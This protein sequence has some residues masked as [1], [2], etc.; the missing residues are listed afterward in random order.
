MKNQTLSVIVPVFNSEKTLVLLFTALEQLRN[1]LAE[2]NVNLQLIFVDDG[3]GDGSYGILR[4]R[5]DT[6]KDITILKLTRNFGAISALKST[7]EYV[8]GDAFLFIAADMQDP[9]NLIPQMVD[10]WLEGKKYVVA[11]RRERN[12]TKSANFFAQIFY[13]FLRMSGV[14]N[15][16]DHGFDLALM[17]KQFLPYLKQTGKHINIPLFPF[18]LGFEPSYI[19]YH[20][21]TVEG[22][23]SSWS[24]AK[25]FNLAVDSLLSFS[26]RPTRILF[27]M[28]SVISLVSF[29]YAIYMILSALLGQIKVPGFATIIVLMSMLHGVT[30]LFLGII[31]E[32]IWR[33]FD[34]INGHPAAVVDI[35]LPA[36]DLAAHD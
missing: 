4:Q 16:P 11:R 20:R 30:I 14:K 32:Y 6:A 10:R 35:V 2:R 19:D 31:C 33:I 23:K 21:L 18:W 26:R 36:T 15:Y 25:K 9:P 7:L 24:F 12:D 1:S 22:K 5:Y 17:D 3:S 8:Q 28:G 27:I 29:L 13:R 34:E